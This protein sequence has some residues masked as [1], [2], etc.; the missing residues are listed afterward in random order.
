MEQLS[1]LEQIIS[2]QRAETALI[3]NREH[4]VCIDCGGNGKGFGTSED[5]ICPTCEGSGEI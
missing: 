5:Y 1:Q 3:E 2:Q 4:F